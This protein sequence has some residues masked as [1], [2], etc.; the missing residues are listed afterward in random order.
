MAKGRRTRQD[1]KTGPRLACGP[2][3][4]DGVGLCFL[5]G[6]PYEVNEGLWAVHST[7]LGPPCKVNTR[8]FCAL[9]GVKYGV[10]YT[11][12]PIGGILR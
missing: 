11:L 10:F 2:R 8:L 1:D 4:S 5:T 3:N 12:Y 6:Y 9:Y 7:L